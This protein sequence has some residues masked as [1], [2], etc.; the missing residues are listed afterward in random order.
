M[1]DTRSAA[2][3]GIMPNNSINKLWVSKCQ[4]STLHS[5]VLKGYQ[6]LNL[7]PYTHPMSS[8]T[9]F[10]QDVLSKGFR[11]LAEELTLPQVQELF[12]T[13]STHNYKPLPV[14]LMRGDGIRV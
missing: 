14:N 11:H 8:T 4:S 2:A 12:N 1:R 10:W 9:T 5:R 3:Y 13:Y 7:S 6:T